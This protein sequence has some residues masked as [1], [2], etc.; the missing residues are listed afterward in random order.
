MSSFKFDKHTATVAG[1]SALIGFGYFHIAISHVLDSPIF[2]VKTAANLAA[3]VAEKINAKKLPSPSMSVSPVLLVTSD[4][5][6]F[7]SL[8]MVLSSVRILVSIF[9]FLILK[10]LKKN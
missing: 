2:S 9:A 4:M 6:S 1:I 5:H 7:L 10:E 3:V 8:L